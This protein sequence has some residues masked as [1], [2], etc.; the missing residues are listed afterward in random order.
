ME[1][2][3][4]KS[5]PPDWTFESASPEDTEALAES[6]ARGLRGGEV[7]F[8]KG[9]LGVGKT[10]FTAALARGLGVEVPV[11]SPTYVLHCSY[12]ARDGLSLEHF[13]FYR[14]EDSQGAEQLGV[15]DFVGPHNIVVVEWPERC[16]GAFDAITMEICIM[17]S[18]EKRRTIEGRLRE[19]PFDRK[20]WPDTLD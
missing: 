8:L 1:D 7:I 17:V 5:D 12:G 10:L 14:L 13:D 20:N 16:P 9:Q 18:G 6:L 19:L 11:T 4:S 2:L 15:E 3:P